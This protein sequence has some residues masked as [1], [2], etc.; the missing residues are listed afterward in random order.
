MRFKENL[1]SH[2]LGKTQRFVQFFPQQKDRLGIIQI[3]AE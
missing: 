1:D 2:I 3:F